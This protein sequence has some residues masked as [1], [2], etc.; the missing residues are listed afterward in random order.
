MKQGSPG[1]PS[2]GQVIHD[3]S[4]CERKAIEMFCNT[5]W[6]VVLAA[7]TAMMV[8]GGHTALAQQARNCAPREIVVSRLADGYGETR[9]SMGLGTGNSVVEVFASEETGTW[10]ITVTTPSGLT[11]LVA[12]GQAF[13]EVAE[14]LP[15]KGS[16]A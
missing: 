12:S 4:L 16:D 2:M 15:A 6:K 3:E 14:A 13:E 8:T 11:C 7:T 1:H 9:Q 10:T 5:K